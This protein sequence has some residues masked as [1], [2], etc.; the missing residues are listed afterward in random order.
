ML[1]GNAP[2]HGTRVAVVGSDMYDEA[3]LNAQLR[4]AVATSKLRAETPAVTAVLRDKRVAVVTG[5]AAEGPGAQAHRCAGG[6]SVTAAVTA[7]TAA[8]A[9]RTTAQCW[10]PTGAAGLPAALA[11]AAPQS[12]VLDPSQPSGFGAASFRPLAR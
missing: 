12:M 6:S 2:E 7:A 9:I 1:Q 5:V 3:H 8:T 4:I 11:K 10:H